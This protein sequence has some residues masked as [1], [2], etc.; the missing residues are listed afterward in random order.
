MG[1]KLLGF[2]AGYVAVGVYLV[3]IDYEAILYQLRI[4]LD[5]HPNIF[6]DL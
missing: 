5:E 1:F 2:K 3:A 4:L 6:Q